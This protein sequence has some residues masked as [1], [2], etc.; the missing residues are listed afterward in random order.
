MM[1]WN[2]RVIQH[3][4]YFGLHEVFYNDDHSIVAYV[5]TPEVIGDTIDEIKSTLNMMLSDFEKAPILVEGEFEVV[6]FCSDKEIDKELEL[7]E[8]ISSHSLERFLED[9]ENDD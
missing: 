1:S 5:E 4:D 7:L 6:G 8:T 2:Y 3:K 9:L